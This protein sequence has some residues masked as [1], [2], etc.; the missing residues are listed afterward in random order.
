MGISEAVIRDWLLL[1]GSGS[2][3]PRPAAVTRCPMVSPRI[4]PEGAPLKLKVRSLQ[5]PHRAAAGQERVFASDS[6]VEV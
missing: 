2:S 5:R 4:G 3:R 1:A 6:F